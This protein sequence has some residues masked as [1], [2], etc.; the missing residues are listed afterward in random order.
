MGSRMRA[1]NLIMKALEGDGSEQR[2]QKLASV[3]G[4]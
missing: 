1:T 2:G 4:Y 3:A